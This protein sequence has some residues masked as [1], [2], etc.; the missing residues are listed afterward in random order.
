MLDEDGAPQAPFNTEDNDSWL[1]I[2]RDAQAEMV[3]RNI[4]K[5]PVLSALRHFSAPVTLHLDEPQAHAF[6]RF[7]GDSD[8]FNRWEAAQGLAKA[9]MLD[10]I[11]D[12]GLI[13]AF[14]QGLEATLRDD[15]LDD[16][17]KALI[18]SLP[19]E[20][21]LAQNQSPIDPAF[22]HHN[23]KRFKSALSLRLH[24]TLR[25]LYNALPVANTFSPD[26]ASAGNRALRNALLDLLLAGFDSSPNP[27][28]LTL[29]AEAHF[30]AATN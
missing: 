26:A 20:A 12:E 21:D 17:F 18:M 9:I 22:L 15:R 4:E 3:I 27:G 16:A 30:K 29:L 2:L 19:T 14:A 5:P 7:K 28:E 24:D 23:R 13:D 6:A 8:P 25:D 1:F 11:P 10:E